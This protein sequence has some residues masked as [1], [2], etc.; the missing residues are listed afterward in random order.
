MH[1]LVASSDHIHIK[2]GRVSKS[3]GDNRGSDARVGMI[4]FCSF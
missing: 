3:E 4:F 2:L 1:F